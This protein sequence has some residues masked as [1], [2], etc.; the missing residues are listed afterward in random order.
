MKRAPKAA[1]T[2]P[3]L[4]VRELQPFLP[5]YEIR[6]R[7][8][9]GAVA[10]VYRVRSTRDGTRRALK[11]L[12]PDQAATPLG[13]Q[14]FEDE[15]RILN[16]LHHPS[17]PDVFDY[18][19]TAAGDRYI[20]MELVEGV[21]LDT[22]FA[23]HHADL[24]LLI[25]ELNEALAFVHQHDLL[26]LDLKPDNI[27]VRK[28]RAFGEDEM[29]MMTLID[30]GLSYRRSDRART[31]AVGT[32]YYMSP[33]VIRR[34]DTL[35]R[36]AD[37]YSLG[38]VLYELI[39][40]NPPFEGTLHEVLHAHLKTPVTFQSKKV[41]YAELYPW[42]QRLLSKEPVERLEAFQEFRRMVATR[43][44]EVPPALARA[45]A[46]GT[47]ESLGMFGKK[48]V[49]KE[50]RDWAGA[51]TPGQTG[52]HAAVAH[53]QGVH[54]DMA[55]DDDESLDGA[56]TARAEVIPVPRVQGTDVGADV[57]AA[58]AIPDFDDASS[59]LES[60]IRKDLLAHA[61]GPEVAVEQAPEERTRYLALSGPPTSG[62][63]YLVDGLRSDLALRG[64][65]IVLL[66][67]AYDFNTLL[68]P[69]G[70]RDAA[71]EPV[72]GSAAIFDR[73]VTG[74]ERLVDMGARSGVVV[75]ADDWGRLAKEAREFLDYVIRRVELVVS[76]GEEPGIY[77]VITGEDPNIKKSIATLVAKE[78]AVVQMSIPPPWA[79][80][81][82]DIVATFHGRMAHAEQRK[83]LTA[84]LSANLESD[85]A[86]T[87]SLREAVADGALA[88]DS[89]RWVFREPKESERSG[90]KATHYYQK[91]FPEL[92]EGAREL[93][94]WLCC[95]RGR[96]TQRQL[97]DL[98]G[99]NEA[100]VQVALENLRP[101][102]IIEVGAD[103][104]DWQLE[105]VSEDV[106]Q[107]FYGLVDADER[108]HLHQCF[109]DYF[110]G[111]KDMRLSGLE[112]LTYHYESA[113]MWRE[114][115]T[116]RIRA[117]RKAWRR[118]DVYS[119]RRLSEDGIAYVRRLEAGPIER[120]FW[121]AE[122]FFIKNLIDAD[123]LVN[124]YKGVIA[125]VDTHI[126][127]M[128]REVPVSFVYKYG[129]S[130]VSAGEFDRCA[131]HLE[132][133]KRDLPGR[134]EQAFNNALLI[135]ICMLHEQRKNDDALGV[136][137]A[138][139]SGIL[140]P[141]VLARYYTYRMLVHEEVGDFD[142][143]EHY[144]QLAEEACDRAGNT[145]LRLR[146]N[147]NVVQYLL[148]QAKH[149][150]AR[151]VARDT[152]RLAS[153]ERQYRSLCT[154]YFLAS[155]VYEEEGLHTQAL[156]FLSKAV[157]LAADIGMAAH[158]DAYLARYAL[159][160]RNMGLYGTA[161]R[162]CE[163]A[164][165]RLPPTG[166]QYFFVSAIALD[167]HIKIKSRRA[168][169]YLT[170]LSSHPLYETAEQSV[171]H[172]YE[173]LGHHKHNAQ[174]YSGALEAYMTAIGIYEGVRAR[175]DLIRT[176]I[177]MGHSQ[178]AIGNSTETSSVLDQLR[179]SVTGFEVGK[180]RDEYE[181]LRL[182][183]QLQQ[184]VGSPDFRQ[185]LTQCQHRRDNIREMDNR[186]AM[187]SVLFRAHLAAG[188]IMAAE[189]SFNA[190]YSAVK[191]ICANLPTPEY[192]SDYVSHPGFSDVVKQFQ[193]I[194]A[195]TRASD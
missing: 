118:E 93:V 13:I 128:K 72:R 186:V 158:V 22:Y 125:Q 156:N 176:R 71:E 14:R 44:G 56:A 46:L 53:Q 182:E 181:I 78:D 15:F 10:T 48:W 91:V 77:L 20:V 194:K 87:M 27:L 45:Y 149:S 34:D 169:A 105:F 144:M 18:G 24:W 103:E 60:E 74:W 117:L 132:T 180:I 126:L 101:Y 52:E 183:Y 137:D 133:W 31:D 76:E 9:E 12:K 4:D 25:Y 96:L 23:D 39:E 166:R 195:K 147:Y 145:E 49:W 150:E 7:L 55:L 127:G 135:E 2:S 43:L 172:F 161:I 3:P 85:G 5:R 148:N 152:I 65:G 189:R 73:F 119:I 110:E 177:A 66:N 165:R 38:I 102:R 190:L 131:E 121:H 185:A 21:A 146:I 153:R 191:E 50:L 75:V 37:Y 88:Y 51:L 64:V 83:A 16:R 112:A 57:P 97:E 63:T 86:V 168:T 107:A 69:E 136:L 106:R 129:F 179:P 151:Q 32:A 62:K 109:I 174:D 173:F 170:E 98:S 111:Y 61:G 167:I 84:W 175:D 33:E 141:N 99:L 108:K 115:L 122:R 6:T 30:F 94:R 81:V 184:G 26:H 11:A 79:E 124:N 134:Y 19:M 159:I 29:P 47:V 114:A 160:Y 171:G 58:N 8:G 155:I 70:K 140:Q 123:W 92:W 154:M 120:S 89:G 193:A 42:V 54:G 41:E 80:E 40:G 130:L 113:G 116:T 35:T 188:D 90:G 157:G 68:R 100:A 17:L 163:E 1:E 162:Y 59:D 82:E 139:N 192:V 143:R 187:D 164:R 95:H 67:D 178:L 142:G 138:I 104:A 28:T 36:A